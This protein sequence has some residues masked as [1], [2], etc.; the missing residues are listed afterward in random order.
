MTQSDFKA[1]NGSFNTDYKKTNVN[2]EYDFKL[3]Q[4]E[5][6]SPRPVGDGIT[7][8]R[9]AVIP[10]DQILEHRMV[11]RM[12]E[13]Y[14]ELEKYKQARTDDEM[15]LHT[16]A[17]IDRAFQ[18]IDGQPA[19]GWNYRLPQPSV[20][21][22]ETPIMGDDDKMKYYVLRDGLHRYWTQDGKGDLPCSVI[23]ADHE[24]FL[25]KFSSTANNEG[26]EVQR[27]YTT[28]R[29]C[30][31]AVQFW[32]K[33]GRLK[34]EKGKEKD[35][36]EKY[37]RDYYYEVEKHDRVGLAEDILEESG[38]PTD[39]R[40][41]SKGEIKKHVKNQMKMEVAINHDDK[42]YRD[43]HVLGNNDTDIRA[44]YNLLQWQLNDEEN[45]EYDVEL[46]GAITTRDGTDVQPTLGNIGK[47]RRDNQLEF[48]QF[49]NFCCD[50]AESKDKLKL[51]KINW[52]YQINNASKKEDPM[53]F[54]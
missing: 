54:H 9:W 6:L 15:F 3:V 32:I 4:L 50:V 48:Q 24:D 16:V 51:P 8:D 13:K 31:K 19:K 5:S 22:L 47:L 42:V 23:T 26:D 2:V 44:W 29:D 30:I 14:P 36:V 41:W 10:K 52:V 43:V 33:Q 11:C 46:F 27:N 39:I 34:L 45:M 28:R 49:I 17:N 37:L 21:K 38:I 18:P 25:I 20:S 12:C 1:I 40:H 35:C 53:K 7:F